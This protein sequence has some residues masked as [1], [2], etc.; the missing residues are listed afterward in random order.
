MDKQR[1]K[2]KYV[3]ELPVNGT[4]HKSEPE[5]LSAWRQHFTDLA[6]PAASDN[7]DEKY[8]QSV[9]EEMGESIDLCDPHSSLNS[10]LVVSKQQVQEA[11]EGI[12]RGKAPDFHGVT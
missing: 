9:T 10:P 11:I 4:V 1:G 7:I 6:T 12:N 3:N 2:P 8:Q 5:I